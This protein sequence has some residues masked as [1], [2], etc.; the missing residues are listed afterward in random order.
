MVHLSE[1][2]VSLTAAPAALVLASTRRLPHQR[3]SSAL[4]S[5]GPRTSSEAA[6][7]YALE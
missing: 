1:V 7:W 5:C 6:A 2:H 3:P 4:Q